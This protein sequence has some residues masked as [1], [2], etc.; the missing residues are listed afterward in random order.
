VKV[1]MVQLSDGSWV[2]KGWRGKGSIEKG[3]VFRALSHI[4]LSFHGQSRNPSEGSEAV[5][6]EMVPT[7]QRKDLASWVS[8]R[9]EK[10]DQEM[11]DHALRSIERIEREQLTRL[12]EKYG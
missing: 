11:K 8:E 2:G 1:W 12:K 9:R 7:G 3:R 10:L 4:M 5:E 6:F